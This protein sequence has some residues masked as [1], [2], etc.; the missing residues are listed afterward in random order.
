MT[1][2]AQREA[3]LPCPFCGSHPKQN[4]YWE[5]HCSNLEC[6]IYSVDFRTSEQWNTRAIPTPQG[7]GEE[8]PW[9]M[10]IF[11]EENSCEITDSP[12][13]MALCAMGIYPQAVSGSKIE[14]E[15]YTERTEFMNGWNSAIITITRNQKAIEAALQST[16]KPVVNEWLPISSP[17]ANRDKVLVGWPDGACHIGYYSDGD[18]WFPSNRGN[19][20]CNK[21]GFTHWMPLP[22]PPTTSEKDAL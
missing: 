14:S 10:A 13:H 21:I 16:A 20:M 6:S 19:H 2:N 9:D 4:A 11:C 17:P 15:N 18:F 22:L 3:L 8:R 5:W 1:T 12:L 7:M